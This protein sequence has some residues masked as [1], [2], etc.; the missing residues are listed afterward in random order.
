MPGKQVIQ[1]CYL[2]FLSR[3]QSVI[4]VSEAAFPIAC[5]PLV[6]QVSQWGESEVRLHVVGSIWLHD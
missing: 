5:D 2:F 1:V 4:L 3:A 6:S